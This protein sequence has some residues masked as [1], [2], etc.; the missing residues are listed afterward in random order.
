MLQ[1][2][3]TFGLNGEYYL[4]KPDVCNILWSYGIEAIEKSWL[5]GGTQINRNVCIVMYLLTKANQDI[6]S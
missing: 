2:N 6:K 5:P 1:S 3:T 4:N